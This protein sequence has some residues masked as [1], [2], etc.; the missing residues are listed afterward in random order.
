MNQPTQHPTYRHPTTE[1]VHIWNQ[2]LLFA[3][4]GDNP[5]DL[6]HVDPRQVTRCPLCRAA[7]PVDSH[8]CVDRLPVHCPQ[9]GIELDL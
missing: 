2:M 4:D 9:C 7:M 8:E 5:P 6:V 3:L 1:A